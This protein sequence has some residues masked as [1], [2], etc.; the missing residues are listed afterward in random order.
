[1][2]ERHLR[3]LAHVRT[4]TMTSMLPDPAGIAEARTLDGNPQ[5]NGALRSRDLPYALS[6]LGTAHVGRWGGQSGPR[7]KPRSTRNQ[8][9]IFC[10]FLCIFLGKGGLYKGKTGVPN[11]LAPPCG[12][13]PTWGRTRAGCAGPLVGPMWP[14]REATLFFLFPFIYFPLMGA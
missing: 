13:I 5:H 9:V 11:L 2:R 8:F 7:E 3:V 1:M 10:I 6:K 12:T 14:T 4:L